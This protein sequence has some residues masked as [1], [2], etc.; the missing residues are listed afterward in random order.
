MFVLTSF[1]PTT[2][3]FC[4]EKK[5]SSVQWIQQTLKEPRDFVRLN[6]G[7]LKPDFSKKVQTLGKLSFLNIA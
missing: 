7:L 1:E 4:H 2:S 3:S 5:H 6:R